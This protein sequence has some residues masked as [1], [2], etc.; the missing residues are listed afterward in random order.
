MTEWRKDPEFSEAI[1]GP[2]RNDSS[3]VWSVSRQKTRGG[4]EQPGQS[5]ACT[6]LGLRGPRS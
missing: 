1:K 5:N 6:R 4:K 2:L 3:Y